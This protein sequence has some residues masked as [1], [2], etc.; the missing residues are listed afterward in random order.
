MDVEEALEHR[1]EFGLGRWLPIELSEH[2]P[3]A[4]DTGPTRSRQPI[5][6]RLDPLE[7]RAPGDHLVLDAAPELVA[8]EGCTEIDESPFHRRDSEPA[9]SG[10]IARQE[11]GAVQPGTGAA[12]AAAA[13]GEPTAAL[14]LDASRPDDQK[15]DGDSRQNCVQNH[16]D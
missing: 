3:G 1:L 8:P 15:A 11:L 5:E 13:V 7:R 2:G 10:H 12:G 9:A 16:R 14:L 6:R 4:G